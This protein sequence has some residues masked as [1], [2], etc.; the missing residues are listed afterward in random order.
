TAA[1]D[2]WCRP[3]S[4][5]G[6]GCDRRSRRR[7]ARRSLGP[8]GVS[9]LRSHARSPACTKWYIDAADIDGEAGHMRHET[10]VVITAPAELVWETLFAVDRWTEWTPTMEHLRR[11]DDGPLKVG[12]RTEVKQPGQSTAIW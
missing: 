9:S 4:R 5:S 11:L 6:A 10:E 8:A 1:S 12:S 3:R 7:R 2:G